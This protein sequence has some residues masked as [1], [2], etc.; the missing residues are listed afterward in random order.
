MLKRCLCLK[1]LIGPCKT[2]KYSF[3]WFQSNKF[4]RP[5]SLVIRQI[6]STVSESCLHWIELNFKVRLRVLH[7]YHVCPILRH[8]P[9][10]LRHRL[11]PR[12]SQ[13]SRRDCRTQRRCETSSWTSWR[14]F[15]M[16]RFL[17]R[18]LFVSIL[19]TLLFFNSTLSGYRGCG[20]CSVD[21]PGVFQFPYRFRWNPANSTSGKVRSF[22]HFL[23]NLF[24]WCVNRRYECTGSWIASVIRL[25]NFA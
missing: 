3:I 7:W 23:T 13:L 22:K 18:P 6:S 19:S 14:R 16:I 15:V 17:P 12:P 25:A 9:P 24:M 20:G 2:A 5:F 10:T 8:N 1:L 21:L 11:S 4:G